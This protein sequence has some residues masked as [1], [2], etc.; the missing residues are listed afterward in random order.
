MRQA[1]FHVISADK[2][3]RGGR[4]GQKKPSTK[5]NLAA[6]TFT[7]PDTHENSLWHPH[8]PYINI[9]GC[10]TLDQIILVYLDQ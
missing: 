5:P 2:Y 3:K 1:N 9:G 8:R 4:G 10:L 7:T 6:L